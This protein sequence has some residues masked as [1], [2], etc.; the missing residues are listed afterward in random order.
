MPKLFWNPAARV[1]FQFSSYTLKQAQFLYDLLRKEPLKFIQWLVMATGINYGLQKY[2]DSDMSNSLGIGV[3]W[4]EAIKVIQSLAE[5]DVDKA[6]RHLKQ[7]VTPGTGIL[8]SGLGPTATGVAKII[9]Q[10]G[11]GKGKEQI[12]KELTPVVVSRL[13]QAYDAVKTKEDDE[14]LYTIRSSN[15]NAIYKLTKRQ[16]IQRTIGPKTAYEG[17]IQK[18]YLKARNLELERTQ[19]LKEVIDAII[20]GDQDRTTKAIKSNKDAVLLM[21]AVP[22]LL[23]RMV[24]QE[25]LRRKY[26]RKERSKVNTKEKF[27]LLKEGETF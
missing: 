18:N 5:G 10:F 4:G 13:K 1:T 17:K 2:L 27:Q 7:S 24:E 15:K 16:L 8:P 11:K 6:W 14:K 3:T 12:V 22:G 19:G 20:S 25:L 21:L 23:D 9:E 26:T